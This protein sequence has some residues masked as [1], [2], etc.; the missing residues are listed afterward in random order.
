MV[1]TIRVRAKTEDVWRTVLV[2]EDGASASCDCAGFAAAFGGGF[3]SH[4]DAALIANERGMVH[5][6]DCATA[7]RAFALIAGRIA[8]P[9]DWKGAWQRDT[10]WR[11]L[12][13]RRAIINPRGSGKLLVCFTGCFPGKKRPECKQEAVAA[14]WDVTDEPSRFTNFLVAPDPQAKTAKLNLARRFSTPI[15]TPEDWPALM[16]DGVLP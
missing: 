8:P 7:D 2:A 5:P 16:L 4:I 3:C 11:K 15:I 9:P 6:A 12:E 1:W 13:R 10:A 14:G